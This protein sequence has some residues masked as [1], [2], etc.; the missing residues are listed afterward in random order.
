MPVYTP[1]ANQPQCTDHRTTANRLNALKS[2]GPITPEGKAASALNALK[3][4]LTGN[5][6]LLD[7]DDA[8]A[9]QQRL[10]DHVAQWKP[11][12]FE[13]R[14]LVQSIHDAAWRLDRILNLEST[15]YAKGRIELQ[16]C[17]SEI[18]E[19]LRKSFIQLEIAERNEKKLRNL[20]LQESRIQRQR[21]KDIAALKQLI[22]ERTAE[23]QAALEDAKPE[24]PTPNG[25]EFSNPEA[26]IEIATPEPLEDAA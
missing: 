19:H 23:E 13:E 7:F 8:E 3:T 5:T 15:I 10:N 1:V 6:V 14:R 4:G 24:P 16:G 20:N 17:F 9:Y 25:F 11:V 26:S 12:T 2:T 21:A 22:A 18:P